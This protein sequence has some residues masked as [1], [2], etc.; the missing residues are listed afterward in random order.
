MINQA[1]RL[2]IEGKVSLMDVETIKNQ[3]KGA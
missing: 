1:N 3:L 2:T